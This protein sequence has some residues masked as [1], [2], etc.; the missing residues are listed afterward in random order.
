MR[1][2]LLVARLLVLVLSC[3]RCRG[4][5]LVRDA[6][7]AQKSSSFMS[8]TGDLSAPLEDRGQAVRP[9]NTGSLLSVA[10][11]DTPG[12]MCRRSRQRV[13]PRLRSAHSGD[14]TF[15][16]SAG[17]MEVVRVRLSNIETLPRTAPFANCPLKRQL[18][19][20]FWSVRSIARAPPAGISNS[21]SKMTTPCSLTISINTV[22]GLFPAF[23]I[24]QSTVLSTLVEL[25]LGV[26]RVVACANVPNMS[27]GIVNNEIRRNI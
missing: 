21:S 20:T 6:T 13:N 9:E 11:A 18:A 8:A 23:T 19:T 12:E 25:T 27:S 4:Y 7:T 10:P 15:T 16:Y 26:T 24:R 17:A 22:I 14:V 2:D 5:G 1:R 3:I